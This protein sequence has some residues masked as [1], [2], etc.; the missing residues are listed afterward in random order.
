MATKN[1][2]G[3]QLK[4]NPVPQRIHLI[5]KGREKSGKSSFVSEWVKPGVAVVIDAD[6]RFQDS[7][8]ENSNTT[9]YP[10]SDTKE[11]MIEVDRIVK[12]MDRALPIIGSETTTIIVDTLTKILSPIIDG[13][14]K[15]SSNVY[16]YAPKAK[17]MKDLRSCFNKWNAETIWVY[18]RSLYYREI[19]KDDG[20]KDYV[21][22]E[23]NS[24]SNIEYS[25]IGADITL[26]LDLLVDENTQKRGVKVLEARKGRQGFTYWDESGTWQDVRKN[27]E[28]LIWGGLTKVEQDKME[29]MRDE[30]LLSSEHAQKWAWEFSGKN[31]NFFS[32]A[33]HVEN[34]Y[35]KCKSQV[36][37][38]YKERG[39]KL[40]GVKFFEL[41]KEEVFAREAKSKEQE[42]ED[43][44]V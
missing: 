5:I 9:F 8:P 33:V 22:D 2:F 27:L 44:E 43:G 4:Y 30:V 7:V 31:G 12:T 36:E 13:I 42:V 37:A 35:N 6:G 18:H 34:A 11:D 21:L 14:Q 28:E 1:P 26:T 24:L 20:R 16:G 15:S 10:M 19:K 25:R 3:T 23:K 40:T 32:D 41:W 17:A 38:D 39:E 29:D